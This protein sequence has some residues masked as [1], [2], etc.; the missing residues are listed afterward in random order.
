MQ[1]ASNALQSYLGKEE[2]EV[3]GQAEQKTVPGQTMKA[4]VWQ[5]PGKVEVQDVPVPDITQD[6]DVILEVTGSTICGSDLHLLQV[7][8]AVRGFAHQRRAKSSR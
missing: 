4:L 6:E 2:S 7:R 1:A 5:K 8:P 3:V